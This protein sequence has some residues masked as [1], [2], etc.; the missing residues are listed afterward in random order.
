MPNDTQPQ[1]QATTLISV[2]SMINNY[3]TKF[4]EI[5]KLLREQKQM[6]DGLLEN[7][8]DYQKIDKEAQKQAKLRTLAKQN[9]LKQSNAAQIQDKIKEYKMQIRDIKTALS[10][11][12]TQYVTISGA[13]EFETPDGVL[14]QIIYSAKL[15]RKK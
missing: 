4:D 6:L 11:Y 14:R 13:K 9:A 10:D 15:A 2:E 3:N 5:D 7:D 1:T 8:A 12:L